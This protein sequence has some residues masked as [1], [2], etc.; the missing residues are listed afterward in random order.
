[1][2]I[3]VLREIASSRP[4]TVP[5]APRNDA[6]GVRDGNYTMLK[7]LPLPDHNHKP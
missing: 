7:S 2:G 3:E 6:N 5:M 1:M 4:G